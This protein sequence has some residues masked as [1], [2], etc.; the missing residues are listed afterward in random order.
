MKNKILAGLTA[1][2]VLTA[3]CLGSSLL[4]GPAAPAAAQEKP[5][6]EVT[7]TGSA[8]I[9]IKP[10]MAQLRVGVET[11]APA[12]KDASEKNA[13]RMQAV[14]D[15]L[16][17][18]GIAD[19]DIRTTSVSIYPVFH[20]PDKTMAS[21]QPSEPQITGYRASNEV[22]VTINDISRTGEVMDAAVT[23][24]ANSVGDLR[25]TVKDDSAQRA[26]ALTEATKQARAKAEAIATGLGMSVS[27]T[28]KVV[29]VSS[30]GTPIVFAED[31][32]AASGKG[33]PLE[34][35]EM[36]VVGSVNVTYL[37]Q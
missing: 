14:I 13:S 34:P 22:Q 24:G 1:I 16:K 15:I 12:A 23:A 4:T 17:A 30:G 31:T 5:G 27:A 7:V 20:Y 9:S 33:T 29:E 6:T 35:G 19:T 3:A 37:C 28:L 2:A 32:R 36:E 8:R 10:N 18:M 25:F 11:S 26:Q 21:D